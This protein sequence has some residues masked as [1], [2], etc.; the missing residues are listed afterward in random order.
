MVLIVTGE[1]GG[2]GHGGRGGPGG[3]LLGLGTMLAFNTVTRMR[4]LWYDD[5]RRG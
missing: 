2:V 1:G 3:G 5:A 4:G